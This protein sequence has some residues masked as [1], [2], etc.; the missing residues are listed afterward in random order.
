MWKL[1]K[2]AKEALVRVNNSVFFWT[3]C[4]EDKADIVQT[5][6]PNSSLTTRLL[7]AASPLAVGVL[8]GERFSGFVVTS[9]PV[10]TDAVGVGAKGSRDNDL[11]SAI[12]TG[13]YHVDSATSSS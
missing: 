6:S 8:G 7:M 10:G 3:C 11:E 12:V 4:V 5:Y 1:A 9:G 2:E 13:M